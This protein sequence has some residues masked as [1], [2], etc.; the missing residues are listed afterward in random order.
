MQRNRG[1]AGTRGR[2]LTVPYD[3]GSATLWIAE[4]AASCRLRLPR[5]LR[6]CGH[7]GIGRAKLLLSHVLENVFG[8]AGASP[9]QNTL[10]LVF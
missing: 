2:N 10:Y 8:S 1:A 4:I 6:N 3:K 5:L 9:S 7:P